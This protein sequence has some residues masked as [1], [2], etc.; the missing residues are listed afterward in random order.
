MTQEIINNKKQRLLDTA[1][2]LFTDKGI[3]NT[4]IQEIVDNANVAKG[5]FIYI[6]KINTNFK[7][8]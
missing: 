1:F 8:F 3:K 4:S 6:L 7:I 5:T 2:S